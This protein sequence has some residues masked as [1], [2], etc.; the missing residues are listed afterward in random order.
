VVV[1]LFRGE[2]TPYGKGCSPFMNIIISERWVEYRIE[3]CWRIEG[4]QIIQRY[5][6]ITFIF[7]MGTIGSTSEKEKTLD[8]EHERHLGGKKPNACNNFGEYTWK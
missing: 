8:Y 2:N 3:H 5:T 6:D 7:I 1:T 4:K